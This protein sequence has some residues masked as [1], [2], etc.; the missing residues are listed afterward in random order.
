[1]V[2]TMVFTIGFS[3]SL[4]IFWQSPFWAPAS[5]RKGQ[6]AGHPCVLERAEG[7]PGGG[8]A[9]ERQWTGRRIHQELTPKMEGWWKSNKQRTVHIRQCK[10]V[11]PYIITYI[12]IYDYIYIYIYDYIY[13]II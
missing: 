7:G 4:K 10:V 13:N 3:G 2:F 9:D 12:Y 8:E 11:Q 6:S 1:M 5:S